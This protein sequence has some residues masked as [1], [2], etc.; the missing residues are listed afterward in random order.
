MKVLVVQDYLPEYRVAFYDIVRSR[1]VRVVFSDYQNS[2]HSS[3]YSTRKSFRLS[4]GFYFIW[5]KKEDLV[6]VDLVV[7]NGKYKFLN[8]WWFVLLK[9]IGLYK[10]RLIY[11]G[12]YF[13]RKPTLLRKIIKLF[14]FK[15]FSKLIFYTEYE[16]RKALEMGLNNVAYLNNSCIES[17]KVLS[18]RCYE[19]T[20]EFSL[21][22]IGRPTIKS[23]F[24]TLLKFAEFNSKFTIHV[25]GF[26]LSD[27]P[28]N[29]FVPSNVIVHGV[30]YDFNAIVPIA[31]SCRFGI[32]LGE[33]GLS[34]LTYASLALPVILKRGNHMPEFSYLEKYNF[35]LMI[36]SIDQIVDA[37]SIS[38]SNY[39]EL[40]NCAVNCALNITVENMAENFLKIV[41]E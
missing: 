3:L 12:H 14:Y 17:N 26:E 39:L 27:L 35:A 19:S 37:I 28:E 22:Y 15:F 25:V 9:G 2:V 34:L 16:A 21:I 5:L 41:S 24:A 11:W 10:F 8:I 32:Y 36:D 13:S 1:G 18:D 31:R 38:R 29:F 23:Q 40:V 20:S 30:I 4:F 7:L 6:D 33:I